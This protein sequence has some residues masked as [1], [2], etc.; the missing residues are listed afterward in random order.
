MR[1]FST[2]KSSGV[3]E[4]MSFAFTSAPLSI[5]SSVTSLWPRQAAKSNG[6]AAWVFHTDAG[7]NTDAGR[8]HECMDEVEGEVAGKV[9][10]MLA[11][12][13]L[14]QPQGGPKA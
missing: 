5:S 14:V 1:P 13:P 4:Y 7:Y 8:I 2:A 9:G 12:T 11:D 6:A 3:P 10:T